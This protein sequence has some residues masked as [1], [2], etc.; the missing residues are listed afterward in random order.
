M[1]PWQFDQR[2]IALLQAYSDS[3]LILSITDLIEDRAAD[4]GI[5]C[6]I[7]QDGH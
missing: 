2:S 4:L 6:F 7:N 3:V 5:T 1:I